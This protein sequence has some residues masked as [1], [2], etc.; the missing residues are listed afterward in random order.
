MTLTAALALLPTI[1]EYIPKVETGV[2]QLI[3]WVKGVR[4]A[5]QQAAVW[6][7]ALETS[8]LEAILATKTDPA[9]QTDAALAGQTVTPLPPPPA[10][11]AA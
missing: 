9:Y 3:A 8:F 1:L 10:P 2:E 4:A 11:P 5:A 6:T 7:P